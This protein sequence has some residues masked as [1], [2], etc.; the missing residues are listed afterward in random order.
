MRWR[1][2]IRISNSRLLE[3][4]FT[5]QMMLLKVRRCARCC[6]KI[7][8]AL[9]GRDSRICETAVAGWYRAVAALFRSLISGLEFA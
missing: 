5:T 7:E 2:V 8:T 4:N 3:V 6:L 9:Y 1:G